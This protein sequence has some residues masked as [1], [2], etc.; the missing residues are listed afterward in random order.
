[1]KKNTFLQP[2]HQALVEDHLSV[3]QWVIYQYITVNETV[4]GLGYDDLYQEGCIW[5]CRAANSYQAEVAKF[6]TYAKTVVRNGLYSYCRKVNA[7]ESRFSRI[8]IGENGEMIADG[9]PVM[10]PDAFARHISLMET[11]ELLESRRYV[12]YGV[13]RLGIEA[14][15]LKLK[16]LTVTQIAELYEVPPAHVGAWISRSLQKLRNDSKFLSGLV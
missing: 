5:L 6:S 10:Q 1:M 8:L 13:A 4:T 15:E 16:G 11:L 3:V 7:N 9:Q 2:D 12:Y 14:L